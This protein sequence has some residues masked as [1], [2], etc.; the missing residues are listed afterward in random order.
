MTGAF[1]T[2]MMV[3]LDLVGSATEVAVRVQEPAWL[4]AVQMLPA[5]APQV[6]VQ[7]TAVSR[8]PWTAAV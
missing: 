8:A 7:V 1:T 4:G 3:L 5:K 2:V 6:A